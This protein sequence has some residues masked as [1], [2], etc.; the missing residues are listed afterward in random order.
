MNAYS[1]R[2]LAAF[3]I[4]AAGVFSVY[5][6]QP[7]KT[8]APM[9]D[10]ERSIRAFYDTYAEDLRG[11]KRESIADRY[12]RRGVYMVGNGRKSLQPFDQVKDHYLT[13]WSGPKAF[14]WKDLSVEVLS[15]E[16]AVVTGLFE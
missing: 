2:T 6:Q 16:T 9:S 11:H 14:S 5:G 10:T 3:L 15:K 8:A 13:K 1:I 12:D 7:A 4:M